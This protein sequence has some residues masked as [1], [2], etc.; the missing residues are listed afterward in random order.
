MSRELRALQTTTG[1]N[2]DR[3]KVLRRV[4]ADL[5]GRGGHGHAPPHR[6]HGGAAVR[7]R[8][9]QRTGA[10]PVRPRG[11]RP[12]PARHRRGRRTRGA[13]ARLCPGAV[14][15]QGDERAALVAV[16]PDRA[17]HP[18]PPRRP[19]PGPPARAL[20][21]LPP[22]PPHRPDQPHPRPGPQR[23][24]RAPVRRRVPDP[25]AG[26]RGAVRGGDH[27]GPARPR[28][29]RHPRGHAGPLRR[30]AGGG[31]GVAAGA[32]A[33]GGGRGCDRARQGGRQSPELRNGQVFRQRGPYRRALRRQ[34]RHRSSA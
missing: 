33:Q 6:R 3:G 8:P 18:T 23:C 28:L 25:A 16:R 4:R 12:G 19:C 21:G 5:L 15:G 13:G 22:R 27:A 11:R 7:H 2:P 24:A 30:G 10:A 34:P 17:A 26:G 29:R 31:L 14:A 20:P 9:G 1:G 32:P